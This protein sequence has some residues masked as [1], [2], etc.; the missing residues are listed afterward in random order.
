[1]ARTTKAAAAVDRK[2]AAESGK[3]NPNQQILDALK[4]EREGYV[5]RGL[6]ARVKQVDAQIKHYGGTAPAAQSAADKKAEAEKAEAEKAEAEKAE[7]EKAAADAAGSGD[8][9]DNK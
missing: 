5:T 6:D 4:S 8:S 2:A 7:A 9:S 3:K 1:M